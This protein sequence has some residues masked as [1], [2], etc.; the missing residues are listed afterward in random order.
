MRAVENIV[1]NPRK[2]KN[3]ITSVTVVRIMD[4]DCAGSCPA[5][6]MRMGIAAPDNQDYRR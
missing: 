3:P 6:V 2:L 5:T 1:A 4:E